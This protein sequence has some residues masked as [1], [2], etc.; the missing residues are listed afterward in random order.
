MVFH[1]RTTSASTALA[2]PEECAALRIVLLTVPRLS[3]SCEKKSDGFDL[4]LQRSI[5]K[6]YIMHHASYTIHHTPCAIHHTPC[7]KHH[8][9]YTIHHTPYTIHLLVIFAAASAGQQRAAPAASCST[10]TPNPKHQT[11]TKPQT[12]HAEHQTNIKPQTPKQQQA[13]APPPS[14]HQP[15]PPTTPFRSLKRENLD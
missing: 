12:S 3:R 1:C 7:T 5:P 2:H 14:Q 13:R 4:H 8:T 15:R 10:Q 11:N 9:P 6:P